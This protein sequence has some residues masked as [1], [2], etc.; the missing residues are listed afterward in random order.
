MCW[1]EIQIRRVRV[2]EHLPRAK[3]SNARLTTAPLLRS[4]SIIIGQSACF[5][6]LGSEYSISTGLIGSGAL[7]ANLRGQEVVSTLSLTIPR[8]RGGGKGANEPELRYVVI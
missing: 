1:W 2:Q 8:R 7:D 3:V 5:H 4:I 6:A